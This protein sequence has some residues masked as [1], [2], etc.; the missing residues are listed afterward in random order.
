M[1]EN[2]MEVALYRE[3]YFI[4]LPFIPDRAAKWEGIA[5][6]L[7]CFL[8]LCL[9]PADN[10]SVLAGG[11]MVIRPQGSW[12]ISGHLGR[13]GNRKNLA[14]AGN[15]HLIHHLDGLSLE[16][17]LRHGRASLL[18]CPCSLNVSEVCPLILSETSFWFFLVLISSIFFNEPGL[19]E[20]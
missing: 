5:W 1:D 15:P 12:R 13:L 8:I 18:F 7:S 10:C 17:G 2:W 14:A 11:F 3:S 4:S 6:I 20:K 19:Y 9:F 16:L